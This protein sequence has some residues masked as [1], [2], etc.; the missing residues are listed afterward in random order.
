MAFDPLSPQYYLVPS[1]ERE[2]YHVAI[3]SKEIKRES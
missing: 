2:V 1:V 3:M